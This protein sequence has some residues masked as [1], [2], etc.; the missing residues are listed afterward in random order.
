MSK[1]HDSVMRIRRLAGLVEC[2]G[3]VVAWTL[4]LCA[5]TPAPQPSRIPDSVLNR[6][7]ITNDADAA[8]RVDNEPLDPAAKGFLD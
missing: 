1:A 2:G 8:A 7:T 6:E 4:A 5:Q 3:L